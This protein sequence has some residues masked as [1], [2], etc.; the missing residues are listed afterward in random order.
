[1][2]NPRSRRALIYLAVAIVGAFVIWIP[3]GLL[4]AHKD[5]FG[6]DYPTRLF[7]R[8]VACT[9][10]MAWA[11]A[12]ATVSFRYSDEFTQQGSMIAWYW[13]SAIGMAVG[14][15]IF[16]FVALGGLGLFIHPVTPLPPRA[17]IA[18]FN[19]LVLGFLIPILCQ[20]VGFVGVRAWWW[21][22]KR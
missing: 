22:S 5:A 11:T 14:A 17:A 18:A 20:F 16:I 3:A 7:I 10:A 15:P 1:M 9:I 13:G 2:S 4:L 21:A 6:L 8:I 12:F 19:A